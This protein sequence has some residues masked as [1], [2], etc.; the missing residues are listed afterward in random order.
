MVQSLQCLVTTKKDVPEQAV[1][2]TE[3]LQEFNKKLLLKWAIQKK[4]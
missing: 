3:I 2:G 4:N 1:E